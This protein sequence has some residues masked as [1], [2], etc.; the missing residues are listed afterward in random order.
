MSGSACQ[1]ARFRGMRY[2]RT[3]L[4]SPCDGAQL[5]EFALS[6]PLLL[7]MVIGIIDFG[8]AYNL[9]QKL[10]NAAREGVRFA[11]NESC[12]DCSK[13][14]PASTQAIENTIVNYLT[15]ANIDVCGLTGTTAPSV[16][17]G[18]FASWTFTS[19]NCAGTS[20]PFTIEVDRSI[21][22]ANSAGV[23]VCSSKILLTHPYPWTFGR[24]IGFLVPG[25]TFTGPVIST[26][27]TMQDLP[28]GGGC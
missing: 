1:A 6:F 22:F 4:L 28:G 5:V 12:A 3:V 25:A 7:V 23:L 19:S 18:A 24:I 14:A 26:D 8:A 17:P 10:N 15:N 21:A 9:K 27:S 20:A 13:A 2:L 16:G 11:I